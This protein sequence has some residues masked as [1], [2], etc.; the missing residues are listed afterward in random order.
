VIVLDS[1]AIVAILLRK[2]EMRF[3]LSGAMARAS[4]Q[5][6]ASTYAIV[7]PMLWQRA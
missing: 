3:A 2:P 6:H 5:K 1:S 4:A 7:P